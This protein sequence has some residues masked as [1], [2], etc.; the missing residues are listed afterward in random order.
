[1][2]MD[3]KSRQTCVREAGKVWFQHPQPP[4]SQGRLGDRSGEGGKH[5]YLGL[6][7]NGLSWMD[8]I[9]DVGMAMPPTARGALPQSVA[10]R[11]FP[12]V[13]SAVWL[14]AAAQNRMSGEGAGATGLPDAASTDHCGGQSDRKDHPA[15]PERERRRRWRYPRC[16]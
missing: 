13:S 4:P 2:S 5:L 7:A 6:S 16:P 11:R 8:C 1:M 15:R 9:G 3:G 14:P 12:V 10:R